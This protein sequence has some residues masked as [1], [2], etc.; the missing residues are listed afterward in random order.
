MPDLRSGTV[1]L[2]LFFFTLAA[3]TG[4]ILEL[5]YLEIPE[6]QPGPGPATTARATAPERAGHSWR[7]GAEEGRRAGP[8]HP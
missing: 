4:F 7:P 1:P 6:N 3:M 2:V 5:R 8:M